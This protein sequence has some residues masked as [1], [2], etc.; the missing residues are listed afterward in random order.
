MPVPLPPG[1]QGSL[2]CLPSPGCHLPPG[3]P[4]LLGRMTSGL[5]LPLQE[6]QGPRGTSW[7]PGQGAGLCRLPPGLHHGAPSQFAGSQLDVVGCLVTSPLWVWL[8]A[9]AGGPLQQ[10]VCRGG[11]AGAE[12]A[13]EDPEAQTGE[14]PAS[15]PLRG[16]RACAGATAA[17]GAS[18]SCGLWG[19]GTP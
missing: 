18:V 17:S 8:Q 2:R 12:G 1:A 3:A 5:R 13:V 10:A 9:G 19:L 6:L 7:W 16:S 15:F 4:S 11:P 14:R